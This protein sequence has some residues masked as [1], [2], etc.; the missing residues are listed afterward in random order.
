MICK[1]CKKDFEPSKGLKFHCSLKCRNSRT[2]TDEDKKKKSIGTK[3]SNKYKAYIK[4]QAFIDNNY[5]NNDYIE[6]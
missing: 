3:N 1:K 6:R 2:W 5:G 4:S